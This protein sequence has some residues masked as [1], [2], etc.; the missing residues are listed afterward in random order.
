MPKYEITSPD[1]QK[2]EVTAPEG[3]SQDEIMAYVQE[4]SEQEQVKSVDVRSGLDKVHDYVKGF[5]GEALNTATFGLADKAAGAGRAAAEYLFGD[6]DKVGEEYLKPRQERQEFRQENPWMA[7][8]ASVTGGIYNPATL[9]AGKW[10]AAA[11]TVPRMMGRGALTGAGT[12]AT[13]AGI[14]NIDNP[15][16]TPAQRLQAPVGAAVMGGTLG[17][18]IPGATRMVPKGYNWF[19]DQ[20]VNRMPFRQ[21]GAANRKLAQTLLRDDLTLE[22]AGQELKRLGPDAA[23]ADLGPNLQQ[24]TFSAYAVPGKGKKIIEKF[25]K[26]R[27]EGVLDADKIRQGGQI[28]RIQKGIDDLIPESRMAKN[29]EEIRNL[30]R[31]AY[32]SNSMIENQNIDSILKTPTGKRAFRKAVEM[33]RNERAAVSKVDPEL[34]AM[35]DEAIKD[36]QN[37]V[38]TGVGVGKGLKLQTLDY[39]KRALSDIEKKAMR[40]G[41]AD[42]AR[43]VGNLRRS[44]T[45]SLDNI[46]E[47]GGAYA[48][49]RKLSG[50]DFAHDDAFELGSQFMRGDKLGSATDLQETMATMS[51]GQL[52]EFRQ[53]MAKAIKGHLGKLVVRADATKQLMGKNELEK[54]ILQG[55]GDKDKFRQYMTML[56]N[57]E[58]MFKTYSDV[59]SNSKTA[60]RL[61]AMEDAGVDPNRIAEAMAQMSSSNPVNWGRAALNL[62]GGAKNRL[63]MPGPMAGRLAGM[64]TGRDLTPLE[65]TYGRV[66][67][68]EELQKSLAEKLTRGLSSY[69][70]A[71]A[72]SR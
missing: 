55:F 52:H 69:T 47:T 70:G 11:K 51:E 33:M 24:S 64:L 45:K 18:A 58:R 34:T 20:T 23:V 35:L 21:V 50:D 66:A 61:A 67:M 65:Q 17:G 9:A 8:T 15:N 37:I 4:Q 1:G 28:Q 71:T 62:I 16:M 49:A 14:E 63:E 5:T 53:G 10:L 42:E 2:F 68:S 56:E 30:Y 25:L 31:Q 12:A 43:V 48:Q 38:K 19:M 27:Q 6:E 26:G 3:A 32:Q 59:F 13:Q 40:T 22:K 7:G 41:A 60:E 39:V 54:R 29:T 36:G 57:E 44:L 72:G 46:D